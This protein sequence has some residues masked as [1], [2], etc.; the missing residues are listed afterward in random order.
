MNTTVFKSGCKGIVGGYQFD[1]LVFSN[2]LIAFNDYENGCGTKSGSRRLY[3]I[4]G[5]GGHSTSNIKSAA[6]SEIG[7]AVFLSHYSE[8]AGFHY[9]E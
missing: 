2:R 5:G 6:V 1:K 3:E 4:P 9:P 7:S 8:I